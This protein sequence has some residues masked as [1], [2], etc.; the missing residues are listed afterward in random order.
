M[1]SYFNVKQ[2]VTTLNIIDNNICYKIT[3]VM[4]SSGACASNGVWVQIPSS[5]PPSDLGGR[6]KEVLLGYRL[7]LHKVNPIFYAYNFLIFNLN[8][9]NGTRTILKYLLQY[10][11]LLNFKHNST[12]EALFNHFIFKISIELKIYIY[13]PILV[14][15][16]YHLIHKHS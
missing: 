15:M 13:A 3:V 10:D 11:I 6:P 5:A 8:Y 16:N 7:G 12:E 2:K 4:L 1:S 14:L 9:P